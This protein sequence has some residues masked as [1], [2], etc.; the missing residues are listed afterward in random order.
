MEPLCACIPL[1][2][3]KLGVAGDKIAGSTRGRDAVQPLIDVIQRAC[4]NLATR[5]DEARIRPLL[6]LADSLYGLQG[7]SMPVEA[8]LYVTGETIVFGRNWS[9]IMHG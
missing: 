5:R 1:Q 4:Y 8:F 7:W 2:K 3:A 9:G 6:T